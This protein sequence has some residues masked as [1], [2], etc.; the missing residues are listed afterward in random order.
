[1]LAASGYVFTLRAPCITADR[2]P[3]FEEASTLPEL[4]RTD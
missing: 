2:P 1:M 3:R 4:F